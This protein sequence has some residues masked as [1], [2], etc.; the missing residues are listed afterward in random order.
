MERFSMWT[1]SRTVKK[2]KNWKLSHKENALSAHTDH[3]N[4]TEVA[5]LSTS[6]GCFGGLKPCCNFQ[7]SQ[8]LGE[9]MST[10][11]D[12]AKE[13]PPVTLKLIGGGQTL[14]QNVQL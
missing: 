5:P 1:E 7:S 8:L 6:N 12:A 10:D 11:E 9:D 13:F 14:D 2:L 3:K 4:T